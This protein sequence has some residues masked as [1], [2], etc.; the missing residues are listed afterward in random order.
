MV[1]RDDTSSAC[2]RSGFDSRWVH[3]ERMKAE[4]QR[5]K[6]ARFGSSFHPSAFI[7]PLE[8]SRI[9]VGRATLLKWFSLAGEEGSTPSP[10]AQRKLS[11]L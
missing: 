7:L 1:Q 10:S 2:W 3:C 11:V 5:M 8:G 6:K 9:P 4:G